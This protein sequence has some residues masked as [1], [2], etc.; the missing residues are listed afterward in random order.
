MISLIEL[1]IIFPK[2][3]IEKYKNSQSIEKEKINYWGF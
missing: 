1:E 3:Q 2:S